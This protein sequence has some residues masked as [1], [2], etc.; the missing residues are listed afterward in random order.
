MSGTSRTRRHGPVSESADQV[1]PVASRFAFACG[2]D[3]VGSL[4]DGPGLSAFARSDKDVHLTYVTTA[5]RLE[6]VMR[7][8]GILDRVSRGPDE[9]AGEYQPWIRVRGRLALARPIGKNQ[10]LSSDKGSYTASLTEPR[11]APRCRPCSLSSRRADTNLTPPS[12]RTCDR[13]RSRPARVSVVTGS[14]VETC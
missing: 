7:H 8:Y 6:L 10:Q 9:N 13:R 1:P 2:T 11:K 4:H 12:R 5:R 14:L 3:V